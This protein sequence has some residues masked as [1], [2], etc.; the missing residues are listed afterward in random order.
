[1]QEVIVTPRPQPVFRP[2]YRLETDIRPPIAIPLTTARGVSWT[3]SS[4]A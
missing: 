1:M 3:A 4:P 2:T